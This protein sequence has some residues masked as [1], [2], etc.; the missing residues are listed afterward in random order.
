MPTGKVSSSHLSSSS[1]DAVGKRGRP[2]RC[3]PHYFP[4]CRPFQKE[5]VFGATSELAVTRP[6]LVDCGFQALNERIG[7]LARIENPFLATCM[8]L[9]TK[10]AKTF[11]FRH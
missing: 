7:D 6:K 5:L 8:S 4:V 3:P 11:G 10:E 9:G 1:R 2:G